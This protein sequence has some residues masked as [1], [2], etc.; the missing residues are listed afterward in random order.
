ML[1]AMPGV[2]VHKKLQAVGTF[3]GAPGSTAKTLDP[4]P[5]HGGGVVKAKE[6]VKADGL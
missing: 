4:V 6:Q 3:G 1:V 2:E 5:A